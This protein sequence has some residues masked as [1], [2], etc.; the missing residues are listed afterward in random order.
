MQSVGRAVMRMNTR[1]ISPLDRPV[2]SRKAHVQMPT[3]MGKSIRGKKL[4]ICSFTQAALELRFTMCSQQKCSQTLSLPAGSPR[5]K[6]VR[7]KSPNLLKSKVYS[8][9]VACYFKYKLWQFPP[10]LAIKTR[11]VPNWYI[12]ELNLDVPVKAIKGP[13]DGV[14]Q[15]LKP[16]GT[17]DATKRT[18]PG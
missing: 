5:Q 8:K 9:W 6:L 17:T 11:A 3:I 12:S 14:R 7:L 4:G 15:D 2:C 1:S 10:E 13:Q 16:M 18:D